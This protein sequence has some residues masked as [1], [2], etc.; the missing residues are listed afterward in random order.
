MVCI[1][2]TESCAQITICVSI[3]A[4]TVTVFFIHS[5]V[6]VLV[7]MGRVQSQFVAFGVNE[8]RIES[9]VGADLCFR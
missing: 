7:L 6:A 1:D 3:P 9:H 8:N 5:N 2:N 4:S